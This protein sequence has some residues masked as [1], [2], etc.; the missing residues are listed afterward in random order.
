MEARQAG[1]HPY[2][3]LL[4]DPDGGILMEAR[5][6]VLSEKDITGHAELNLVRQASM[7]LDPVKV[8]SAT[9]Y[10]STEPCPMCAGAVHWSGVSRLVFGLSQTRL[11]QL[12]GRADRST[13]L[14]LSCR[15]ILSHSGREI[16][17]Y[18]P[19]LEEEAEAAHRGF[20]I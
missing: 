19:M 7:A 20:W 5:N 13:S 11:Y 15:T 1:N 6:T 10:A 2:G 18:G 16:E 14:R 17:I 12:A 9:L 4:V 3:A 8:A